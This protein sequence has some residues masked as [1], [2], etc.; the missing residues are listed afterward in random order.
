MFKKFT[1]ILLVYEK[2][3]FSV[4]IDVYIEPRVFD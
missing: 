2:L 3:L 1:K 4:M